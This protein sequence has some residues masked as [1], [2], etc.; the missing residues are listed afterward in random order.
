[1]I[2][3][4][5]VCVA[6]AA[7]A[8]DEVSF[9]TRQ[10]DRGYVVT[11]VNASPV[12]PWHAVIS[13]PVLENLRPS[14]A[15]PARVVL[16]PASRQDL[17]SLVPMDPQAGTRVNVSYHY[18]KGDPNAVPDP[19]IRYLFPYEH[20]TKRTV[21]QGYNGATTH[22]GL[23]ALDFNLPEGTRVCAARDGVVIATRADSNRGGPGASFAPWANYIEILHADGTWANYAHL[24][25]GGVLVKVGERVTAGQVIGSSGHTG[26]ASGPHLHFVVYRASWDREGGESLPTLFQHLDAD[27]VSPVEGKTYYAVRPGGPS[28]VPH[29]GER[30]TDA[31]LE[32]RTR[33]VALTGKI[34]VRSEPVDEKTLLWCANGMGIPQEVTVTFTRIAGLVPSKPVPFT[35]VVP[36][37]TEVYLFSLSRAGTANAYYEVSWSW[38]PAR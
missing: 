10:Q 29:L 3:A 7:L 38:R 21:D 30:L 37:R 27:P 2:P 20:G 18:G 32:D 15:V 28:F 14:V 31:A 4:V 16:A 23:Y 9:T 12:L 26:E 22:R 36:A 24:R 8:A 6:T 34:V 25:R 33:R 5:L 11:G 35:R 17:I 19:A 1:M 13:F